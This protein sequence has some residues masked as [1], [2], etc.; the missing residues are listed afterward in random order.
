MIPRDSCEAMRVMMDTRCLM[1]LLDAKVWKNVFSQCVDVQRRE[2][3]GNEEC[4]KRERLMWV[5]QRAKI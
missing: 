5:G 2:E 4:R 3:E 1:L